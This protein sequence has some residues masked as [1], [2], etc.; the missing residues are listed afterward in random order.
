MTGGEARIIL[1]MAGVYRRFREAGYTTP[2]FLLP[3]GEGTVLT[4]VIAGLN[5]HLPILLVANRRDEGHRDAILTSVAAAGARGDLVFVGDTAGQAET[6]DVG[7][8]LA[9]ERGWSGPALFHNVDTVVEGRNLSQIAG[10][11][12]RDDG[13]IDTFRSDSPA[14]S[15]VR[16]A[17]DEDPPRVTEIAEKVVISPHATTGLYGFRSASA[18][19]TLAAGTTARSRGEFY[20]SDVYATLLGAGGVIRAGLTAPGH[21][22]ILLG[23]PAEYEAARSAP[24]RA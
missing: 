21:R 6:A 7:A 14:F 12:D 16:L 5:P 15:Y 8:R 9:E 18:Y 1:C 3:F 13:F 11:L 4:R 2:K 17:P 20:V 24:G 10:I 23:T 22:T 19:R